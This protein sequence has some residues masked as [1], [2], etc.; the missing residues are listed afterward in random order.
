MQDKVE[1]IKTIIHKNKKDH[2]K[3]MIIYLLPIKVLG[4]L[5]IK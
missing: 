4:E 3:M 5:I 2:L 1:K